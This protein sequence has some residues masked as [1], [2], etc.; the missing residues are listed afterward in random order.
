MK[1]LAARF[2]G[3]RAGECAGNDVRGGGD[4]ADHVAGPVSYVQIAGRTERESHRLSELRARRGS[5][6]P[7]V[8]RNTRTGEGGDG[9]VPIGA[10]TVGIVVAGIAR[11]IDRATS[12][13]SGNEKNTS[14]RQ[15]RE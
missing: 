8:A 3:S 4:L 2:R 10:T 6:V 5:A 12:A 14:A 7:G 15:R 9:S 1:N 13:A 11:D